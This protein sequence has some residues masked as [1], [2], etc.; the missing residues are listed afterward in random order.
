VLLLLLLSHYTLGDTKDRI[1]FLAT[2]RVTM[3]S[4]NRASTSSS[5]PSSASR[6]E[7]LINVYDLLPVRK[8]S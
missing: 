7:V 6:V 8:K 2:A 4:G 3:K 1:A 5:A